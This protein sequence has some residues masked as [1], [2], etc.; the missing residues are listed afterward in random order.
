LHQLTQADTIIASAKITSAPATSKVRT[1][2]NTASLGV[3]ISGTA[4]SGSLTQGAGSAYKTVSQANTDTAKTSTSFTLSFAADVAGTYTVLVS[5]GSGNSYTAGD[6]SVAVTITTVGAP[7]KITVSSV[8]SAVT[9]GNYGQLFTVSLT[10]ANGND[11][12][13][14]DDEGIDLSMTDTTLELRNY[15]NSAAEVAF[16]K[17]DAS[18]GAYYVYARHKSGQTLAAGTATITFSGAGLLP[19]TLKTNSTI[20]KIAAVV[21]PGSTTVACTTATNCV[22]KT[23]ATATAKGLVCNWRNSTHSWCLD[24]CYNCNQ[25]HHH[26]YRSIR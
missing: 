11:T 4:T 25:P 6:K 16:D 23:T 21:Y 7:A 12:V 26:N 20:N 19:S 10:D 15:A 17:S 9:A 13:L 1:D 24:F 22:A 14:S 2:T 18:Y 3:A 5:V 8:G